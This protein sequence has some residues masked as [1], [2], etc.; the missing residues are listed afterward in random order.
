M[1]SFSI[2]LEHFDKRHKAVQPHFSSSLILAGDLGELL[3]L[4]DVS[5]CISYFMIEK[6]STSLPGGWD[7]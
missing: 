3:T 4:H 2:D 5:E 6:L 7:P 1:L